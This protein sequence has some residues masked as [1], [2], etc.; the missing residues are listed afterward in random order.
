MPLDGSKYVLGFRDSSTGW[1]EVTQ[2]TATTPGTASTPL[3]TSDGG[4]TW[5]PV[6][7][8]LH[9]AAGFTDLELPSDGSAIL[10]A[11]TGSG[12]LALPSGDGGLTWEEARPIPIVTTPDHGPNRVSFIDHDHWATAGASL[13]QMTSD[14]GRTWRTMHASLPAGVV[15]L[16]DVWLT[17]SGEGW[18]TGEDGSGRLRVLRTTDGGADWSLSPVPYL[19]RS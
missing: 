4:R 1:L 10:V 11:K 18:A 14:A 13:L 6:N 8:P 16:V 5:S 15:A 19:A 2:R 3:M 9:E 12:Y 17:G 7:I